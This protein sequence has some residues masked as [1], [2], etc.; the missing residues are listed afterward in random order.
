MV[1]FSIMLKRT[2]KG[3]RLASNWGF[4]LMAFG[5]RIR[6][7][8]RPRQRILKEVKINSGAHV[9]DYGCGP[10]SYVTALAEVVGKTGRI[11]ALDA[12]PLAIRAVRGIASRKRLANVD[13]VLSECAIG[14][15]GNSLDVVLLYDV[16]HDLAE[17]DCVLGEIH[18]VLKPE[19]LL[20]V[21]DH[22]LG[23]TEIATRVTR[24]GRFRLSSKGKNTQT[25]AKCQP[26]R[27][28]VRQT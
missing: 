26:E 3:D 11:Y 7:F 20:S 24:G 8:L 9:L 5:F 25:Y 1:V 2:A 23:E 10:G 14:L 21:S 15:P 19:G 27:P 17:P 28:S 4:R 16:L 13:A 18:R 22:H 12:H 6:D